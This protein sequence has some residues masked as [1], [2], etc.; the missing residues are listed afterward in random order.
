MKIGIDIDNTINQLD[1]SL[2][3]VLDTMLEPT[4]EKLQKNLDLGEAL[5]WPEDRVWSFFEE[6]GAKIHRKADIK[7]FAKHMIIGLFKRHNVL[8][9]LTN[10]SERG[11]GKHVIEDTKFWLNIHGV[12]PVLTDV[13]HIDGCKD[14]WCKANELQLDVMVED[15]PE[16]AQ[17]FA[18][19]GIK[20][21]LFNYPY[22][23]HVK[24]ENIIRVDNWWQA[25]RE[26]IKLQDAEKEFV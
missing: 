12:L 6:Y 2:A 11:L 22:N 15:N 24:H 20:V 3:K 5:G 19:S 18:E 10:R 17:K 21:V 16:H 14:T 7:P 9:V 8:Y 4:L 1:E 23:E 26:I 25:Y 13:I